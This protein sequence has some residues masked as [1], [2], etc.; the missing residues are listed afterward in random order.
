MTESEAIPCELFFPRAVRDWRWGMSSVGGGVVSRGEVGL[1]GP[2][3]KEWVQG[4]N[5][6]AG[7][8]EV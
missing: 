6:S 5:T 8:L 2:W 4:G 1:L 3:A 7:Q